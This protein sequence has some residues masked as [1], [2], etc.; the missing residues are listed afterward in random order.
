M[1]ETAAQGAQVLVIGSGRTGTSVARHFLDQGSSVVLCDLA[2]GAVCE[3]SLA[4]QVE[5][6]PGVDG[7]DLVEGK[8]L[9]VPSPGVPATAPSLVRAR[10]LGIPVLSE[11]ELAAARLNVP[12]LAITGTNGKS[13][14]TELVGAILR[15]ADRRPFVGG[16]LGPPLLMAV[17]EDF[18]CVVAEIS[19]FQLE[20]V[21]D[22]HPQ[23]A[24]IL[25]LTKDHLDRH[26]DMAAYG[27]LKARIFARQTEADFLVVNRDDND[28]SRLAMQAK[29]ILCTFGRSALVGDGAQIFEDRIE[30]VWDSETYTVALADVAL[31]GIHNEENMAAALLL[32]RAVGVPHAIALSVLKEFVGLPHRMEWVCEVSGVNFVDDSKGTNV[33]AL[34][35]SLAGLPAGRVVLL[36]GGRG[37]GASFAPARDLVA[38]QARAVVAYGEAADAI[39]EAWS[40]AVSVEKQSNFEDAFAAAWAL[41]CDGDTLLLSPACASQDQFANYHERGE[42]FAALARGLAM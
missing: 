7:V 26:G 39:D 29:A 37:K 32:T 35:K 17:G 36:A 21:Q 25:N 4:L 34:C 22:F 41:A 6:H 16:N 28:V 24:A 18:D 8:S 15:A 31:Q 12:M 3:A 11:I 30:V 9:V 27:D 19:S 23:V 1:T 33:G 40:S 5:F 20:W 42:A 14:T 13:T 38:Q 2:P 10:S